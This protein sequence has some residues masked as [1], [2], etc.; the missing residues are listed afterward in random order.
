MRRWFQAFTLVEVIVALTIAA[1][2]STLLHQGV[3]Q[4]LR[5][6]ERRRWYE[7][8]AFFLD[9]SLERR[10]ETGDD[11]VDL[12]VQTG[13]P[14]KCS[15]KFTPATEIADAIE[16]TRVTIVFTGPDFAPGPIITYHTP[17]LRVRAPDDGTN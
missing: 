10:I 6:E 3:M 8:C 16:L 13:L 5:A 1:S 4:A 15:I 11:A 14:L 2:G 17:R 12:P 7:A 9:R